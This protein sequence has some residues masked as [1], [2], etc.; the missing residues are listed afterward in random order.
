MVG[1]WNLDTKSIRSERD[2]K[3]KIHGKSR[4][5]GWMKQNDTI[6]VLVSEFNGLEKI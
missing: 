6:N 1:V 2:D 5:K 3:E 4:L